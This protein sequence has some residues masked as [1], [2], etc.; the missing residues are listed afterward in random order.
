[1]GRGGD[2]L[3]LKGLALSGKFFLCASCLRGWEVVKLAL[4]PHGLASP[5]NWLPTCTSCPPPG[6]CLMSP[7]CHIHPQAEPS[8][9]SSDPVAGGWAVPPGEKEAAPASDGGMASS[10]PSSS[11]PLPPPHPPSVPS[12]SL[13][14]TRVWSGRHSRPLGSCKNTAGQAVTP[15]GGGRG[16]RTHP[17]AVTVRAQPGTQ[18]AGL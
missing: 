6:P 17:P 14:A 5:R 9:E 2:L 18:P 11:L 12:L 16:V 15:G 10:S 1:M 8:L 3:S 7:G 4:Q 13:P